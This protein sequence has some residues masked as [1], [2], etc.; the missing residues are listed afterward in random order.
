MPK[1]PVDAYNNLALPQPR[2][3][4]PRQLGPNPVVH[5][6]ERELAALRAGL[7]E[8]GVAL[9]CGPPGAGKTTLAVRL[10]HEVADRFPGGQ[11]RADLAKHTMDEVLVRFVRALTEPGRV[12][13]PEPVDQLMELLDTRQVLFVLD[14]VRE[15]H[16]LGPFHHENSAVIATSRERLG[17]VDLGPMSVEDS[18]T[19]LR[20]YLGPRIDDEDPAVARRFVLA[21]G[22]LPLAL[23]IA[24]KLAH[25]R[26][27]AA[28]ATLVDEIPSERDKVYSSF[29]WAYQQLSPAE[30]R[31][32]RLLGDGFEREFSISALNALAGGDVRQARNKLLSLHL[33]E[34]GSDDRITMHKLLRDYAKTLEPREPEALDRLLDHYVAVAAQ[35][36][37]NAVAAVALADDRRCLA[38]A[39]QLVDAMS[40]EAQAAAVAAARSLGDRSAEAL[41][42]AHLGHALFDRGRLDDAEDCHAQ[43]LAIRRETRALVGLANVYLASGLTEDAVRLYRE[44]LKIRVE[45]GDAHGEARACL[46]LGRSTGD[47]SYY[48]RARDVSARIGDSERL[49]RAWNGMGN[50]HHRAGRHAEAVTCYTAALESVVDGSVL[51]NLGLTYEELGDLEKA[52]DSY[53]R[54][55]EHAFRLRDGEVLG[56]AA[57]LLYAAG[58]IEQ[59][60]RRMRQA[61]DI[62]ADDHG[63]RR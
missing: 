31:V 34:N 8:S 61:E 55:A 39:E 41:A 14:N 2:G 48:E 11:L 19:L 10:A 49:S 37:E 35:E 40:V 9:L 53:E 17:G 22:Q 28:L 59:A 24:A 50:L 29:K 25:L 21:C 4:T 33:L 52:G 1:Y 44:V 23:I 30:A 56:D 32:F 63:L 45:E 12:I 60:L 7:E 46:S 3:R 58:F 51:L 13:E 54:A 42:L 26:T 5:G 36:T 20:A 27:T 43:A 47:I 57:R 18:L 15:D 62:A 38:L 6:R 16:D